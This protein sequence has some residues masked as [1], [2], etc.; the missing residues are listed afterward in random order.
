MN[1]HRFC[2]EISHKALV[3]PA[4]ITAL[5]VKRRALKSC[6]WA[7]VC[8]LRPNFGM[9]RCTPKSRFCI[10]SSCAFLLSYAF[11][12]LNYVSMANLTVRILPYSE[13]L[14]RC[15]SLDYKNDKIK[16]SF[17]KLILKICV[18]PACLL[19]VKNEIHTSCQTRYIMSTVSMHQACEF[20]YISLSGQVQRSG[21]RTLPEGKRSL[22]FSLLAARKETQITAVENEKEKKTRDSSL[23]FRIAADL[24]ILNEC[25][26]P[27]CLVLKVWCVRFMS[28]R[29]VASIS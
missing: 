3:S 10:E 26:G 19:E 23:F 8:D 7:L 22:R 20:N 2:G 27:A 12:F 14:C 9:K 28:T 4:K 25:F 5:K 13:G 29:A 24:F 1:L 16:L 15:G 6:F 17:K 18:S 11:T 21:R